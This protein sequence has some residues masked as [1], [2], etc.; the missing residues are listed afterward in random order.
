MG[1]GLAGTALGLSIASLIP[2]LGLL[3]VI[4]A[5]VV[6]IVAIVKCKTKEEGHG[7][8][9]AGLIISIVVFVLIPVFLFLI[10]MIAYFGVLS[11]DKFLPERMTLSGGLSASEY[12][13]SS[14]SLEFGFVNNMGGEITVQSIRV[15]SSAGSD[16]VCNV[17][18][19]VEQ[20]LEND[21][22]YNFQTDKC[23]GVSG[24]RLDA[25]VSIT[26]LQTGQTIPRTS[27]GQLTTRVQ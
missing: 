7:M 4:P 15:S 9:L 12:R 22:S 27:T 24:Q 2:F 16:V 1:K 18:V 3:F 26:T 8:A 6:S 21:E 25:M 10:G 23:P 5:L 14:S 11:P 17:D 19:P 13:L 20:S